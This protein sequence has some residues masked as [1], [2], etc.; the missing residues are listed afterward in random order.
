VPE[1]GYEISF[2]LRVHRD[3]AR[4]K[5]WLV[6]P[7]RIGETGELAMV[8]NPVATR[9]VNTPPAY[10]RLKQEGLIYADIFEFRT[11]RVSS[12]LRN[13]RIAKQAVPDL[14][15]RV[16]DVDALL[17]AGDEYVVDGYLGLDY[18][19]GAFAA[20]TIETRTLWVTL[21]LDPPLGAE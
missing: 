9:F 12:L 16:R 8:P 19:F 14:E 7:M 13:V 2:R 1:T 17:V 6:V 4:R 21:R 10:R 15:V 11:G 18:L 5:W 20:I 3:V